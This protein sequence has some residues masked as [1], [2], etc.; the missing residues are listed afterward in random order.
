VKTHTGSSANE[1]RFTGELQDSRV[2]RQPLYLRARYYD[3]ALGC[4]LGRDPLVGLDTMPQTQDRYAYAMNNPALFID[5][6]GLC[7]SEGGFMINSCRQSR[8]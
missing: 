2:A 5:P 4:F 1:W 8:Q 6:F 3:P 7:A